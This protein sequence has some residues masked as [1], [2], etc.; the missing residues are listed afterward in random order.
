M[1]EFVTE[2]EMSLLNPIKD[3]IINSCIYAVPSLS[4]YPVGMQDTVTH[5]TLYLLSN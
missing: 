1:L 2:T 4:I 5:L 3:L